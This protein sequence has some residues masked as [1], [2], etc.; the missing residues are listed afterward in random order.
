MTIRKIKR[1][2][3]P[4]TVLCV[5][6]IFILY[7]FSQGCVTVSTRDMAYINRL[8]GKEEGNLLLWSY[9]DVG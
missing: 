8:V 5:V 7:L 1:M 2:I 9:C 3:V 6:G 4:I